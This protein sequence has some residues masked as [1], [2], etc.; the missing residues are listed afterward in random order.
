MAEPWANKFYHTTAWKKC[1][2]AFVKLKGG[3]CEVCHDV[4]AEVHHKIELT[5]EN[6]NDPTISLAFD[7]LQLLCHRCHDATKHNGI[8]IRGDISFD[9]NGNV[10]ATGQIVPP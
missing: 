5:P 4:G 6:V 3:I 10:V 9:C 7:N 8:P 2:A 1:R